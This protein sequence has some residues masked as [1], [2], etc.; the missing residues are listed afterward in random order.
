MELIPSN[1]AI[2]SPR[3]FLP[4][5][6]E[7]GREVEVA[8][9]SVW[10]TDDVARLR[11]A[12]RVRVTAP[13]SERT[14]Q[15]GQRLEEDELTL[16]T[17]LWLVLAGVPVSSAGLP[18]TVLA[19]LDPHLRT[20]LDRV[21][22]G[23]LDDPEVRE[24]L[25][26]ELRRCARTLVTP[27][28]RAATP[29]IAVLLDEDSLLTQTLVDELDAQTWPLVVRLPTSAEAGPAEVVA[30]AAQEGAVFCTR[31]RSGVRYAPHH[32]AD[33]IAA[34]QHSGA[35]VAHSPLRFQPWR[36]GSWLEDDALSVE[37][38]AA[39]GI[40][41]GS[42]WYAAD[43]PVAP[44]E[45]GYAIHGCNAVPSAFVG[46]PRP[47]ALRHHERTPRVL[48]WLDATGQHRATRPELGRRESYF[49]AWLS[50][51]ALTCSAASDS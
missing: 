3:G 30:R 10:G 47:V 43:G 28:A 21:R 38:D 26:L 33:L 40:S 51:P 46:G 29:P 20:L 31:M 48:A 34:L 4:R 15:P 18:A 44:E 19:R 8:A 49:D 24:L 50:R 39:T 13:V 6:R 41:G 7:A 2:F 12:E 35:R 27:P 32:L 23:P 45:A 25:S 1:S 16:R 9:G 5:V 17:V 14:G 11:H 37:G 42:V 22:S 36:D